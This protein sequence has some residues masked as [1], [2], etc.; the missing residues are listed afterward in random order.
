MTLFQE[1]RK[2]GREFSMA[3]RLPGN[4][5]FFNQEKSCAGFGGQS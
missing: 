5:E 4:L 3:T 2:T 1:E